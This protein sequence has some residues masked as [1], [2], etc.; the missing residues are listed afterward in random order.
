M[1]LPIDIVNYHILPLLTFSIDI[2]GL[3]Y[4]FPFLEYEKQCHHIQP[5]GETK[6]YWDEDSLHLKLISNYK[7]GV[8]YGKY[9]GY[10]P[11]GLL[12]NESTYI[13]GKLDGEEK[14]YHT[15]GS[16]RGINGYSN[17]QKNGRYICYYEQTEPVPCDG[18]IKE[19]GSYKNNVMDGEYTLFHIN[20]F[21]HETGQNY[22][23]K[24]Y[25]LTKV[26]DTNGK[27]NIID[28]LKRNWNGENYY[29]SG[30]DSST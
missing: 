17:G 23:G 4:W 18:H 2:E 26:Y 13:N 22:N 11:N 29:Y 25:G 6:M 24:G 14:L 1:F 20:G 30:L 10:Y 27:L 7:D 15:N 9:K 28:K 21:V 19:I 12:E 5:H 3:V 16:I 8:L